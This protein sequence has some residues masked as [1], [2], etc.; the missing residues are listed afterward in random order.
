MPD[1]VNHRPLGPDIG[2]VSLPVLC[3]LLGA[4]LFVYEYGGSEPTLTQEFL[5]LEARLI[6]DAALAEILEERTAAAD[7]RLQLLAQA[8]HLVREEQELATLTRRKDQLAEQARLLTALE[9][10][11]RELETARDEAAGLRA[12][13]ATAATP[14]E[15]LFGGYRGDFVLV[16]CIADAIIL[17]PDG[18]HIPL[19]ELPEARAALLQKIDRT[20][21]VAIAVRPGGWRDGSFDQ[22]REL[23]RTPWGETD[24]AAPPRI[25]WAEFPLH[26]DESI[27]PYLPRRS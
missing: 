6:E 11:R 19:A 14:A 2:L 21:H 3:C 24:P 20:G 10:R 26:A 22:V 23:V 4:A 15:L 13:Q 12:E 1:P 25:R 18:R 17:H 16:E 5:D 7:A 9:T 8:A 27:K